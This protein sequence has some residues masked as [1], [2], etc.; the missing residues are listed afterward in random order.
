MGAHRKKKEKDSKFEIFLWVEL[1]LSEKRLLKNIQEGRLAM[2]KNMIMN[3]TVAV[4]ARNSIHIGSISS[5]AKIAP[6]CCSS[7]N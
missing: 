5:A 4:Y 2:L 3:D 1:G 7:F 6:G